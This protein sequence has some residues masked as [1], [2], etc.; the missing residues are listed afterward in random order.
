MLE[1]T[2]F[3]FI[4]YLESSGNPDLYAHRFFWIKITVKIFIFLISIRIKNIPRSNVTI[5]SWILEILE[6]KISEISK[7]SFDR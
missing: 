7:Q 4:E 6:I 1:I 5:S 3:K 2:N